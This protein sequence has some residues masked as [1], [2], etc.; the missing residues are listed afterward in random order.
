MSVGEWDCFY[1][2]SMPTNGNH[3]RLDSRS[4]LHIHRRSGNGRDCIGHPNQWWT[5]FLG[6]NASTPKTLRIC[7]LDD[8]MVQSTRPSRRNN[9]YHLWRGRID[10]HF[11]NSQDRLCADSWKDNWDIRCASDISWH[12]QHLRRAHIE[13]SQQHVDPSSLCWRHEYCNCMS[14]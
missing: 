5:I 13:I 9:R 12:G 14:G 11:G 1:H 3:C 4:I 8:W 2:C 7:G 6:C 10:L